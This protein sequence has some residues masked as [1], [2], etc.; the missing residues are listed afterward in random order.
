[1][2]HMG[3]CHVLRGFPAVGRGPADACRRAQAEAMGD[4]GTFDALQ[5]PHGGFA[6][7]LPCCCWARV[8]R[9]A[10]RAAAMENSRPLRTLA[11]GGARQLSQLSNGAADAVDTVRSGRQSPEGHEQATRVLASWPLARGGGTG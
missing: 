8:R 7:P 2:A 5:F 10:R 6:V 9:N 1:V 3:N 11:N 4:R